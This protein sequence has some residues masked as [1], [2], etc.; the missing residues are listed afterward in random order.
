MKKMAAIMVAVGLMSGIA[1]SGIEEAK[2]LFNE[3]KYAEAEAEYRKALPE[4]TGI[5]AATTQFYV[6]SCLQMQ[7]K[8]E[9]AIEE[10][11]KVE[12]MEGATA[13]IL[14]YAV[15]RI[16]VCLQAVKKY[17]QAIEEYRR[18]EKIEKVPGYRVALAA[19]GIGRCYEIQKKNQEALAEYRKIETIPGA[20]KQQIEQAKVRIT[21]I[22]NLAKPKE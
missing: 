3:Q 19:F 15:Y 1:F 17:D 16:G 11:R 6:G 12:K 2:Q 14:S 21:Y 13:E 4:L 5:K 8:Y 9:E 10:Y 22:E 20:P 7:K 18:V